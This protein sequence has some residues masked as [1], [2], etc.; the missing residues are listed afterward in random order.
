MPRFHF[1]PFV[2]A[3]PLALAG[4][5]D[6]GSHR[7]LAQTAWQIAAIDGAAAASPDA[8]LQFRKKRLAASAGCNTMVGKWRIA[9]GRLMSEG[10]AQTEVW[11]DDARIM[12]QERALSAL[13]T[14]NPRFQM[15]DARLMLQA[16]GHSA[17]L[18]PA[19]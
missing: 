17:E 15:K 19:R 3:L 2:L 16:A 10:L 14:G 4:C 6:A 1:I 13:L 7:P 12:A 8:R 9:A 5:A 18:L 11:C